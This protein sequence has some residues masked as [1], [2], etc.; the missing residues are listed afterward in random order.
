MKFDRFRLDFDIAMLILAVTV[1]ATVL[2]AAW[3]YALSFYPL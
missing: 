1:S 3:Y 2:G